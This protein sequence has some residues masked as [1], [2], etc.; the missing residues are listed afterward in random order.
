MSVTEIRFVKCLCKY[1]CILIN[2]TFFF[3]L[4]INDSFI[5]II[6]LNIV[7]IFCSALLSEQILY[8]I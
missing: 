3:Q 8:Y 7:I 1:L 5:Y 2:M 4:K 6:G